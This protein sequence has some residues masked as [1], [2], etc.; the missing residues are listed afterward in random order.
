MVEEKIF[1]K[2]Y[3]C[4]SLHTRASTARAKLPISIPFTVYCKWLEKIFLNP[5]FVTAF[6]PEAHTKLSIP[7]PFMI[8]CK[9][10]MKKYF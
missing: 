7:I 8:N 2:T 10:L 9:W 1:F 3:F 5:A 6:I 4:Y